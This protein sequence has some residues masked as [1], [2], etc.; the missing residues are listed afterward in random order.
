MCVYIQVNEYNVPHGK[1]NRG[2]T[3]MHSYRY[4]MGSS[5]TDEGEKLAMIL[6][7]CIEWVS[8]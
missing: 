8:G 6:G 3:V 5:S 1:K 2:M 7:W 4:L